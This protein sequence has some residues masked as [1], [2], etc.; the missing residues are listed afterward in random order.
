MKPLPI[1]IAL[2]TFLAVPIA[3][4]EFAE[5]RFAPIALAETVKSVEKRLELSEVQVQRDSV[6][7]EIRYYRGLVKRNPNDITAKEEIEKLK[8]EK[9]DLD[10]RWRGLIK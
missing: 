1:I 8:E 10:E 9:K 4:L 3:V 7:Q 6:R 2:I 5:R